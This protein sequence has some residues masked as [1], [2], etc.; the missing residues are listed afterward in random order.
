MKIDI[1]REL[2]KEIRKINNFFEINS[3][4]SD[5]VSSHW[6]EY[7]N[8]TL[9]SFDDDFSVA[10]VQAAGFDDLREQSIKNILTNI[11]IELYLRRKLYPLL[12]ARLLG[13]VKDVVELQ[14][15][16]I[17]FNCIKQGLCLNAIEKSGL[18]LIGKKVAIIGDGNGFMGMLIKKLF[19][20]VKIIQINL[21]K[22]LMF[23]LLFTAILPNTN[24]LNIVLNRGEYRRSA[25]F[26]FVPAEV[27]FDIG[28]DDVD[29]FIN[30]ASMQ[31]MDVDI[32]DSYF[33]LIR[34]Q[35]L[36]KTHF[37]CCNRISKKLPDGTMSIFDKYAWLDSDKV[38]FDEDCDWYSEFPISRPPFVRKFDGKHKHR[39]IEV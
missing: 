32:V 39:L 6:L 29:F 12:S 24:S 15:R 14:R 9:I 18:S 31:E 36:D 34:S 13:S 25:D 10:Y 8:K 4:G 22:I 38:I 16:V 2:K 5:V 11:P 3:L 33:K 19:P 35:K 27:V 7:G 26:N 30:I 17:S 1:D 21:A 28:L 20:S 23:D 37:Y